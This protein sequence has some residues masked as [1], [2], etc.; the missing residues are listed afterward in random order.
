METN[1]ID[2]KQDKRFYAVAAYGSVTD[3][4]VYF[5]QD[6]FMYKE[7]Q[8]ILPQRIGLT[9]AKVKSER[10]DPFCVE[11]STETTI[12]KKYHRTLED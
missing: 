8:P 3:K 10:Y 11:V 1:I 9:I 2:I 5:D 7:P 6:G 12:T 4:V